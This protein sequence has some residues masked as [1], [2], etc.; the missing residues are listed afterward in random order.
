M[1]NLLFDTVKKTLLEAGSNPENI[2]V[3]I[4]FLSVLHTWGQQLNLHPHLHCIVPGGGIINGKWVSCKNGFFINTK[5]LSRLFKGKY[6]YYFKK[7]HERRKLEFFNKT[8]PYEDKNN[9]KILINKLYQK[10]WVVYAK[11]PFAGPVPK[12]FFV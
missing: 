10:E 9:F 6:L 8:K 7:I 2:G 12:H 3:D 11:K 5:K 1:Y 4:G